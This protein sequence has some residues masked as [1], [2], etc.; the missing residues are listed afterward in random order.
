MVH[1]QRRFR[2]Q[3]GSEG[4]QALR[5]RLLRHQ[6]RNVAGDF[7]A[8]VARRP[9]NQ[10]LRFGEQQCPETVGLDLQFPDIGAQ[11]RLA[12]GGADTNA[13]QEDRRYHGETEQ[14]QRRGQ[15]REFLVIEIERGRD[16]LQ[17]RRIAGMSRCDRPECGGGECRSGRY[18]PVM[19]TTARSDASYR[20][21]PTCLP[22]T[23]RLYARRIP[24]V[25]ESE[26]NIPFGS[27]RVRVQ[28]VNAKSG[29]EK[30]GI[31]LDRSDFYEVRSAV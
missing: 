23:A 12:S 11:P 27:R 1:L 5:L 28:T 14:R 18:V 29:A 19:C 30:C 3:P 10:D 6:Q 7:R 2:R 13:R 25:R 21:R 8:I 26:D 17:R 9:R 31:K 20:S 15:Y 24:A 4:E 16:R 22:Q